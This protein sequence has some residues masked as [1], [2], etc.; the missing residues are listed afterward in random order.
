MKI[1][2]MSMEDLSAFVQKKRDDKIMQRL[3]CAG[4][5]NLNPLTPIVSLKA[6]ET[7]DCLEGFEW[8]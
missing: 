3:I 8:I 1:Q 2:E 4:C 5:R 6:K 7:V